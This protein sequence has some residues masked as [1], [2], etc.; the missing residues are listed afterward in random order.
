VVLSRRRKVEYLTSQLYLGVDGGNSSTRALV[1]D[2][3]GTALGYGTGGNSNYQSVGLEA[4]IGHVLAAVEEACRGAGLST[5]QVA[6]T[7]FALAG[8]D[9]ADDHTLLLKTLQD[10]LPGLAF[11]LSN[12]VWAGLRAGSLSGLGVAV[13]CGSG[14]GAVGR[15]AAGQGLIIPD[16]GYI[17]GDSGGGNQIAV[18]GIRAVIRAWDGR[19]EPTL[20]TRLIL[21]A[22]EQP[23]PQTLYTA[24]YRKQIGHVRRLTRVVLQASAAGDSVAT[25]ILR[26][27]GSELG[28]SGAAVVRRLGMEAESFDLVLTGGTFRTLNSALVDAVVERVRVVAPRCRPTLPRLMPVAGAVLMAMDDGGSPVTEQHYTRLREQGYGWHAEDVEP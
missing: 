5:A 6:Y 26:R 24:V 12:D 3:A 10:R 21:D 25:Q 4:A 13:N 2:A 14:C 19:G 8:D 20:L 15:N 17:F 27:I 22:L 28:I 11:G 1:T 7:Y 16:V 23:D 18:D 9:V